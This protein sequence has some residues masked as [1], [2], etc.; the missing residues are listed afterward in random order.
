MYEQFELCH[1]ANNSN[2]L[3]KYIFKYVFTFGGARVNGRIKRN[4]LCSRYVK[5]P[6][7]EPY[8]T[9]FKLIKF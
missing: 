8:C 4:V 7:L 2:K 6:N 9:A 1:I 3:C 5:D